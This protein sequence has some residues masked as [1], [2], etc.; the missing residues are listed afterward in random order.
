M[1]TAGNCVYFGERISDVRD[2]LGL[3][4]KTTILPMPSWGQIAGAPVTA[5]GWIRLQVNDQIL[6][7]FG[8]RY[9][10]RDWYVSES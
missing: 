6:E 1:Q 9:T 7:P 3:R 10:T 4:S 5:G 8:G 2:A